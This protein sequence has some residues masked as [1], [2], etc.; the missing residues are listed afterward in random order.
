MAENTPN[1]PSVPRRRSSSKRRN[2]A[3]E[4]HAIEAYCLAT[5]DVI[6]SQQASEFGQGQISMANNILAKLQKARNPNG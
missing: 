3:A 2:F 4:V 6:G 5:V 1:A